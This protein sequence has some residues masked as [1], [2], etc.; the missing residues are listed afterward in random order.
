MVVAH[1]LGRRALWITGATLL[2]VTVLKLLLDAI[3][4]HGGLEQSIACL[5]AGAL[6]LATGW[7]A[8]VP[9]KRPEESA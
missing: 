8:P 9:P 7:F 2:G 5:G 1:R 4:S 3:A 6:M